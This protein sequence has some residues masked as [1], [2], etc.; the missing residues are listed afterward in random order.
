[1]S[2]NRLPINI[3]A[4]SSG[5]YCTDKLHITK[6]I[7]V[8]AALIGLRSPRQTWHPMAYS[9]AFYGGGHCSAMPY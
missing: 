2:P 9:S 6:F 8:A 4:V 7:R 1:M 5:V 3:H